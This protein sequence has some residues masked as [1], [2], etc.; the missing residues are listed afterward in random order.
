MWG[1]FFLLGIVG[2]GLCCFGGGTLPLLGFLDLEELA[3]VD[4]DDRGLLECFFA[5]PE[6]FALGLRA[7]VVLPRGLYSVEGVD[8]HQSN[9]FNREAFMLCGSSRRF[10]RHS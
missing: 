10:L 3:E 2:L 6:E 1:I 4:D 7:I 9:K 8:Y 5:T